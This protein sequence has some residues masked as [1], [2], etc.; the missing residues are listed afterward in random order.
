[1][2]LKQ[3]NILLSRLI[4]EYLKN[5]QYMLFL[6]LCTVASYTYFLTNYSISIDDLSGD[7]YYY[8]EL[9]AQGRFTSTI[10]RHL[11]GFIDNSVWLI[12]FI[13]IVCLAL[14][15]IIFC[16][17]FDRYIETKS[18]VPQ[19]VFSCLFITSPIYVEIFPYTGCTLSIGGGCVLVALALWFVTVFFNTGKKINFLYSSLLI[20]FATSWYESL[21]VI[22]YGAVFALLIL[23]TIN[24]NVKISIKTTFI[25][26]LKF[27]TPLVIG[28]I[29]EF[30]ISKVIILILG[31]EPS[32]N[33][34]NTSYIFS[35]VHLSPVGFLCEIGY[36][37]ILC[38]LRYLPIT[39]LNIAFVVGLILCI[40]LSLSKKTRKLKNSLNIVLLFLGLYSSVFILS[41]IRFCAADYRMS[42][43]VAFFTAFMAF[44]LIHFICLL[45]KKRILKVCVSLSM[46]LA[47]ILQI[48]NTNFWFNLDIQ[49]YNEEKMVV[50]Q[51][52]YTLYQE[53]DTNK[54]VVFVGKYELSDSIK[55]KVF[56]KKD[57][58][59]YF[60][61]YIGLENVEQNSDFSDEYSN[62]QITETIVNSY[63]TWGVSA[64]DEVNT[65]LLKFFSYHGY[66]LKQGT[67]EM[68][69]EALVYSEDMP[70]WPCSGSIVDKGE[71]IIVNF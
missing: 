18:K 47:V 22:Y 17:L 35:D 50:Q 9:F 15:A 65:E 12:D 7:R 42:Q 6:L 60:L 14:S 28:I 45:E 26:G 3:K 55:E 51:I 59:Y 24:S 32:D 71:Y 29:F 64:F 10:I 8:G 36:K 67:K 44:I 70:E 62:A 46:S 40:S 27:A 11:F 23:K 30:L 34:A 19:I 31:I 54:P 61:Q 33:S 21:L 66:E 52:G 63:I 1:M 68:Y 58:L 49:R 57:L 39:L 25:N 53:Y 4:T 48:S 56:A 5:Y 20:V 13:G 37:Y 69:Q 38:S 41:I 16:V 43:I 2:E